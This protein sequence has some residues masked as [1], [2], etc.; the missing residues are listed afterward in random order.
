MVAFL[1]IRKYTIVLIF[2]KN[3]LVVKKKLAKKLTDNVWYA[4]K[5]F[6]KHNKI[7]MFINNKSI[8][9]KILCSGLKNRSGTLMLGMNDGKTIFTDLKMTVKHPSRLD[10]KVYKKY[11]GQGE[12]INMNSL[13]GDLFDMDGIGMDYILDNT[14]KI[15]VID[16]YIC[17]SN[18][19][20]SE[21]STY[22]EKV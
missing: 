8:F 18:N 21:R 13:L 2:D 17:L 5:I 7:D 19:T 15:E 10:P 11:S 12:D 6:T 1:N 9:K 14:S 3:K 22:C 16:E 20:Q 4:V